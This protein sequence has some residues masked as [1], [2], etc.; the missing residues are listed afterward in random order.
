M[1]LKY[2]YWWHQNVLPVTFIDDIFKLV[3]DKKF[4]EA[5]TIGADNKK[6]T[7]KKQKKNKR[8]TKVVFIAEPWIYETINPI[9]NAANERAGW[10]FEW[11][12]NEPV[13]FAKYNTKKYYGWHS[14]SLENPYVYDRPDNPNHHGKMR[15]LSTIISLNDA[16][17]YEGGEVEFD[18]RNNDVDKN[19]TVSQIFECKELKRKGTVVTFPSHVWH[20]VKPITKGTRYSLVIWH[21]GWPFK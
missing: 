18:F 10:N 21:L 17:E 5:T 13:Q 2:Y 12:Y 1:L 4:Q 9:V 14:D 6:T 7:I 15:K 16:S 20:R 8:N 11:D 19:K 3:K